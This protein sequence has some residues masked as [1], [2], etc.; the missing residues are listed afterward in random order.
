MCCNST[1][2]RSRYFGENPL[3][4]PFFRE[5]TIDSPKPIFKD[6]AKK[7]SSKSD[8]A[9]KSSI[10][11]SQINPKL[12]EIPNQPIKKVEP[13]VE[14]PVKE[15]V[16]ESPEPESVTTT[17]QSTESETLTT[18]ATPPS[19]NVQAESVHSNQLIVKPLV[20]KP[21][22]FTT[23]SNL[24][25][26]ITTPKYTIQ[27]T[28]NNIYDQIKLL[29]HLPESEDY[30]DVRPTTV[31]VPKKQSESISVPLIKRNDNVDEIIINREAKELNEVENGDDDNND[32]VLEPEAWRRSRF[33]YRRPVYEIFDVNRFLTTTPF[34]L[35]NTAS[36]TVLPKDKVC[37]SKKL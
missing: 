11:T 15:K 7:T 18:I 29:D 28:P 35:I 5:E 30:G 33:P 36:T 13:Q 32:V 17:E 21:L 23:E 37:I 24:V 25:T 3:D 12:N 10:T 31:P 20:N 22:D 2:W 9:P 34:T 27:L 19:E 8:S 1:N 14:S 6:L 16:I 26:L 4:S